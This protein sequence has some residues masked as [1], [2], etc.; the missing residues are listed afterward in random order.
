VPE[1]ARR[2]VE[3]CPV[4][5]RELDDMLRKAEVIGDDF[6]ARRRGE[7]VDPGLFTHGSSAQRQ[8]WLQT[9]FNSGAPNACDS[10]VG[11]VPIS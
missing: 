2:A 9:G 11:L 10:F 3:K 1:Q 6:E 7:A 4:S 5:N 8:R